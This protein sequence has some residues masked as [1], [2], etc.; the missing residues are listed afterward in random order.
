MCNASRAIVLSTIQY[1][2]FKTFMSQVIYDYICINMYARTCNHVRLKKNIKL[3][4]Y[5]NA[6][7]GFDL[8]KE[9][10]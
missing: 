9:R 8:R 7:S 3:T 1:I 4:I 10:T 2:M 5:L 6:K